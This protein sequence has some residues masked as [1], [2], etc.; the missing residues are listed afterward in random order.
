MKEEIKIFRSD[1][2]CKYCMYYKEKCKATDR[3]VFDYLPIDSLEED[4]ELFFV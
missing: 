3:C 4:V 2:D 1:H